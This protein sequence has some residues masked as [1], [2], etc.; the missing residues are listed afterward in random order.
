MTLN[1]DVKEL[2]AMVIEVLEMQKEYFRTRQNLKECKSQEALLRR[3]CQEILQK[4]YE[5]PQALFDI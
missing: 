2:A 5:S 3:F 1:M 4:P